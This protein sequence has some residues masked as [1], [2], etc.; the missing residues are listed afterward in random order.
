V[1]LITYDLRQPGRN[2]AS[3]HEAIRAVGPWWHYLESA[4]LVD[5]NQTAAGVSASL[6]P[7]IDQ[8]D[9]LLIIGVNPNN[10]DGWL[11]QEAWD[12]INS[13]A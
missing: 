3:L 2:Y 7:H 8:N 6:R 9:G 13:H 12:W 5:T 4:W 1:L 11:V 10:R